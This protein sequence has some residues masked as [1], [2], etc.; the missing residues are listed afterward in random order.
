MVR[1]TG[2]GVSYVLADHHDT[3]E[4]SVNAT[5]LAYVRRSTTPYGAVRG[6]DPASWPG[7]VA[8]SAAR[9]TRRWA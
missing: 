9:S 1:T 8:S 5:T 6:T 4:L 3:G 7:S 2:G